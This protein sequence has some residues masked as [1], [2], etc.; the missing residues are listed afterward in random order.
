MRETDR[1]TAR[2]IDRQTD[3]EADRHWGVFVCHSGHSV[4]KHVTII[5]ITGV[6]V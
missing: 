5:I 4:N 1:E 3:R 2:E 6:C